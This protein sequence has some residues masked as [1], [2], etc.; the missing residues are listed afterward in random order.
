MA[1][2]PNPPPEADLDDDEDP[3]HLQVSSAS[4]EELDADKVQE[5]SGVRHL[6]LLELYEAFTDEATGAG[7][8]SDQNADTDTPSPPQYEPN[9][10][11]L[12]PMD[13]QPQIQPHAIPFPIN[14]QALP[15]PASVW[16]QP[17][18]IMLPCCMFPPVASTPD[19]EFGFITNVL[20]PC[21][22]IPPP[23]SWPPM[24]EVD[25]RWCPCSPAVQVYPSFVPSL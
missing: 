8:Q 11:Q 22:P 1:P 20:V 25:P 21:T 2:V 12:P 14:P 23:F 4:Q 16:I 10:L 15:P 6:D 13:V 17:Q 18:F 3:G 9:L 24:G 19:R 5:E 7:A